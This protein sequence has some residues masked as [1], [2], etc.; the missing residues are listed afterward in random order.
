[1]LLD[2]APVTAAVA[3][4]QAVRPTRKAMFIAAFV[5]V[6]AAGIWLGVGALG[7]HHVTTTAAVVSN[8]RTTVTA[9]PTTSQDTIAVIT[10]CTGVASALI[11]LGSL[12]VAY[13]AWR[14]PH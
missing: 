9:N 11:A 1:M 4:A 3:H 8:G 5:V 12:V 6:A 10:M 14:R 2:T 7:S 13:L